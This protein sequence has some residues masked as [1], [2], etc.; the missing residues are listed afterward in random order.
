VVLSLNSKT[1][2]S[3]FKKLV[4][5]SACRTR[6][7][8]H[9]FGSV[10]DI[11]ASLGYKRVHAWRVPC[12]LA[13]E[14]KRARLEACQQLLAHYSSEGSDFSSALSKGTQVGC[15]TKTWN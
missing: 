10:N 7:V 2:T 3:L 13:H 5:F 11:I 14:V 15:I 1:L 9:W 8:Q 12:Q 6:R 4:Y